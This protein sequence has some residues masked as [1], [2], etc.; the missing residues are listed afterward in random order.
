MSYCRWS[1]D[2]P[3]YVYHDV[4]SG[5]TLE[6]QILTVDGERSFTYQE[7]KDDLE[8]CLKDMAYRPKWKRHPTD[9]EMDLLEEVFKDFLSDMYEEFI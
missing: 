9:A 6:S 8:G 7:L 1:D 2:C 3:W 4:G 5:K